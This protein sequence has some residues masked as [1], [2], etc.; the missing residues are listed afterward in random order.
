MIKYFTSDG[1]RVSESTIKQNLSKAYREA[2]EGEGH[3]FCRGCGLPAQGSSHTISKQRCKHLHQSDWIWTSW[4]F[5][6]ACHKCNSAWESNDKTLK[7]YDECMSVLEQ[8]DF[9]G[10]TKRL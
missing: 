5:W 10:F 6:P 2:Y 8:Y 9:E 1:S 4:N 3:P 7:N